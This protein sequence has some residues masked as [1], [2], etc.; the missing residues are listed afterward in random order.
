[1]GWD[2][3]RRRFTSSPTRSWWELRPILRLWLAWLAYSLSLVASLGGFVVLSAG[4]QRA[5]SKQFME[6]YWGLEGAF[7]PLT[8]IAKLPGWLLRQHAGDMAGYPIG[9]RSYGSTLTLV[10]AV[11]GLAAILRRRQFFVTSLCLLPLVANFAA[12][13]L[14]A[15]PY[16]GH[17]RVMLYAAPL[18]CLLAGSGAAVL[19]CACPRSPITG[20][21]RSW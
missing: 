19:L 1:M 5:A 2:G 9:G 4:A 15:Y 12:A 11:A 10:C 20:T 18:F 6:W 3:A 16:G 17:V 7:P 21:C 14:K 8:E 13:C